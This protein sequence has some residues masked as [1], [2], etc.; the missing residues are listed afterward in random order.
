MKRCLI[1]VLFICV[2]IPGITYGM[3]NPWEMKLPFEKATITYSLGGVQNGMQTLYIRAYGEETASYT[4]AETKVLGMSV[5]SEEAEFVTPEWIYSYNITERTGIKSVNPQKYLIEEF[6]G[7]SQEEKELVAQNAQDIGGN[8]TEG[9]GGKLEREVDT[10][11]GY[12]ADRMNVMGTTVY[13]IHD[14]NIPLKTEVNMMGMKM[15]I[16]ATELKEGVA[17][18]KYFKHPEG[19]DAVLDQE[20]EQTARAVAKQTINMLKDPEGFTP[21]TTPMM[22]PQ[23]QSLSPEERKEMEQAMEALKNMFGN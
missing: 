22:I 9:F 7:L 2:Y 21:A 5:T 14:T 1:A 11:L 6:N 12:P 4:Q 13:T 20:S 16:V 17:Q 18:A 8:L 19:I 15:S 23:L 3:E 10:I